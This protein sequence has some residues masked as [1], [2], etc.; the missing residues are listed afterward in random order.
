MA[1]PAPPRES[2]VDQFAIT[3]SDSTDLTN[4]P[5]ALVVLTTGTI[6]ATG[7]NSSAPVDYPAFPAGTILPISV[8]RV[9]QTGTTATLAGWA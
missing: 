7:V 5:L 8:K 1:L 9:Y 3:T 4:I 2:S 6:R